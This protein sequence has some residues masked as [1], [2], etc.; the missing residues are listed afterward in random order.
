MYR[1]QYGEY[2]D[3]CW[4]VK[5]EKPNFTSPSKTFSLEYFKRGPQ[6]QKKIKAK[7]YSKRE[8]FII[9]TSRIEQYKRY[10]P[11]VGQARVNTAWNVPFHNQELCRYL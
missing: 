11:G 3:W 5:G 10:P 6:N 7:K 1:E 2:R 8:T 4:G 9:E